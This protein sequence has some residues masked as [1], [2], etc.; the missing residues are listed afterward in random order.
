MDQSVLED[1][2]LTQAEIK[3]YI[4]LLE[5]GSTPAG[6]ILE[7]SGL[8]NSVVHR[9]LHAL[10]EKG[11]ISYVLEGKRKIY[12]ATDPEH[13]YRFMDDKR[14]R[15]TRLLPELKAKQ[16]QAT[17]HEAATIY[18]GMRGIKEVY[19]FM[20]HQNGEYVT[21]GGGKQCED[22]MGTQWWVNLHNKRI[23][24]KL[25]SRQVFD[26]SVKR[27]SKNIIGK[28]LTKVR[29]LP[30]DFAS[31]QETI[32]VGDYV[33]INVFTEEPYSFLIHDASVA[34]GYRK[35]FEVLWKQA[36]K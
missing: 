4:A 11:L 35:H 3:T 15:F 12:Q 28:K 27:F 24:N 30:S 1:L 8:Q 7:R 21:F 19:A 36:K 23:A 33:A 29:F 2:G 9:A 32:I 22:R 10:I 20:I 6:A 18:K 16:K 26:E 14:E 31:F 17:Q 13:F 25:P 5:L 34:E